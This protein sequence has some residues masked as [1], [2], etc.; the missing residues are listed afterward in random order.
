MKFENRNLLEISQK[1]KLWQLIG[2]NEGDIRNNQTSENVETKN[3]L[4]SI[5][6]KFWHML[7]I[8]SYFYICW[9][10]YI[11]QNQYVHQVFL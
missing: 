4:G 7:I 5:E 1:E 3:D 11:N 8:T 10:S 2:K 6:R 9:V